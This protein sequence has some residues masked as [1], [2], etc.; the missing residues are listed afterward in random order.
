MAAAALARLLMWPGV[1]VTAWATM[2][3]RRSNTAL[4]RSP[5]SRTIGENAARCKAR[6]CSFTVAISDCHRTSSS[7]ESNVVVISLPL[8]DQARVWRHGDRPTGPDDRRRFSFLDDGRT[9]EAL[10]DTE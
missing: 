9:I 2:R 1:P 6:A 5:A 4:A 3:P 10:A 7:M 8:R